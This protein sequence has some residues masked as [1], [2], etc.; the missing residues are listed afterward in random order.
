MSSTVISDAEA[1]ERARA[2]KKAQRRAGFLRQTVRWHWISAAISLIGMLAFAVTGFTL[3]HAA[4]IKSE[5]KTVE[6]SGELPAPLLP[7]LKAAE[8][9]R[10]DLPAPVVAWLKSEMKIKARKGPVEWSEGEAYLGLPGPGTDAWVTLDTETGEAAYE[11]TDRG[12]IAYLNDL[13]KG[14]N[15]GEAWAWF[16]D[17]FAI[18]C[19]VFCVTGLLLLQFHAHARKSTWP[20][21][22]AGLLIPLLLALFLVH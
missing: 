13:H 20:L 5:P 9:A 7:A 19:V 16:I 15:S 21:V 2:R 10:G 22:G 4:D 18:A 1:D 12:A 8:T 11:R 14:R 17:V 3:N 6:R